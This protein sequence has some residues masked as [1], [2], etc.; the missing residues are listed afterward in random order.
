MDVLT[1]VKSD[2]DGPTVIL[3]DTSTLQAIKKGLL[4]IANISKTAAKTAVFKHLQSSLVSLGQ[5]CDDGCTVLLDK[6]NLLA[7]KNEEILLRGQ[8]STSGYG[9]WDIPITKTHLQ[10]PVQPKLPQQTMNVIIRKNKAKQDLVRYLHGACFSPTIDTWTEAIKRNHFATWPGLNADLVRKH[11]PPNINTAKGHLKQEKQGLQSTQ[12]L[13]DDF[14]PSSDESSPKT[15]DI[16]C[17]MVKP[18]EKAYMDLTGRFPYCS[19]RGNEYILVAYHY[20]ANAILGVPLK[21]RQA[22]T[23]TKGWQHLHSQF[24]TAGVAPNT[25]IL[26]NETSSELQHAMGKKKIKFQLVPPHTHRANAAERAIQTFKNHFKAGI[27]SL[28]PDF[29]ISE[30]D[31][32]LDQAFLTLNL[33]RS[34]RS[35]PKLSAHAYLF[36][37]FDFNSTPL[38]PPGTKV[39]VHSKPDNRASWDPN[40]KEGWYIGPSPNH[41]RCMKCFMPSARSEIHADTIVFFSEADPIPSDYNG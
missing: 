36:G 3:P 41:Y 6:E 26:D 2:A 1:N 13:H 8:R 33:L 21:N 28:D 14:Y 30:W 35:Q 12:I 9:L 20:D 31:R 38:A 15:N 40:G 18:G 11:L 22:A 17:A 24:I 7:L 25:W 29:P 16:I 27:A 10:P 19:S 5:L 4:P 37:Q 34:A 32:L 39:L 23:I